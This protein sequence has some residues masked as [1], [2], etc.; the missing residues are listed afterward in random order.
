MAARIAA[1]IAARHGVLV[2]EAGTGTGKTF[3]YLVPALLSG[4]K[5]IVSTG[6]KTLQDQ[7][8][9]TRPA[10]GARRAQGARSTH[11]AAQGPRQLRLPLPPGAG[12]R[13]PAASSRARRR[14]H[15][16]HRALRQ[17]DASTGDKA[18]CRRA[19]GFGA[20]GTATSTRDNCLGQDCPN[21][22][23]CFVMAGAARGAGGRR[24]G[25]QSPPVLRRRDAARR[26]R[27]R[28]AA[29]LQHG[30]LR[31]GAPAARDGQPVLRRE[32]VD[33]RSCSSWRATR[34]WKAS[35]V[36]RISSTCRTAPRA[37]KGGAR[38]AP[39]VPG[40][41]ARFRLH[42][43]AERRPSHETLSRPGRCELAQLRRLLETRRRAEGLEQLLARAQELVALKRW[44]TA[45]GSSDGD[46]CAGS[47]CTRRRCRS[48]P[49][50][51]TSP[52]SS[53]SQMEGHPRAWIFTSATLAVGRFRAL[54][55]RTGP[56][57]RRNRRAGA[58]PS[59]TNAGAALRAAR[60]A[61]PE[62]PDVHRSG[63]R[64]RPGR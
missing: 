17:G 10:D 6:T 64:R 8:V 2:A 48:T 5:V 47:R 55:R 16:R 21:A 53:G 51:S 42:A 26:G 35:P 1:A 36:R 41:N 33:R 4:G 43:A 50:R 31:R 29:G 30:D 61:R 46:R 34:A 58:A 63:G 49:R 24:G 14:P 52:T 7:S 9:P 32:R 12:A 22:K 28:A 60:H 13:R 11:R 37:G 56:G 25:G 38:P 20:W 39:G 62:Q 27:G 54:L 23:E 18:E 3:A 19:G 40:E 57:E 15:L 59:T 44:R 45:E